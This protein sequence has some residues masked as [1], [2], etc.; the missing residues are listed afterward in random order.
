[1]V[2]TDGTGSFQTPI[3]VFGKDRLGPRRLR[4]T[5]VSGWMAETVFLAELPTSGPPGF[6]IRD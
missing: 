6:L 5:S 1:M 4:G 2:Q 3:L